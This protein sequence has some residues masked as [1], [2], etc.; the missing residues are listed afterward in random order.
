TPVELAFPDHHNCAGRLSNPGS[1]L[2]T[3]F[4][5]TGAPADS[6]EA[7]ETGRAAVADTPT[8][9]RSRGGPGAPGLVRAWL[10]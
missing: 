2:R 10:P 3:L 8:D 9:G 1:T 6:D 4:E 7:I 5:R